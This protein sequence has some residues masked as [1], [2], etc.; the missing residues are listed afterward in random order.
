MLDIKF[1]RENKDIVKRGAEKKHITV[2][3]DALIALDDKR[4]EML[5]AVEA[6]RFEQKRMNNTMSSERDE[7]ARTQIIEEKRLVKDDLK[8]TYNVSDSFIKTNSKWIKE[9]VD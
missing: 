9:I 7:A 2:D 6:L 1:I 8:T 4:L 3:I 5:G